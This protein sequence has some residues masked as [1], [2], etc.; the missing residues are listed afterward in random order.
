[1]GNDTI[2]VARISGGVIGA[3]GPSASLRVPGNFKRLLFDGRRDT[4][5]V[6]GGDGDAEEVGDAFV[7]FHVA[8]AAKRDSGAEYELNKER[9]P[10]DATFVICP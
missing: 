2:G 3:E 6:A 8:V 7:A 5:V 4:G 10:P 9:R 1:M